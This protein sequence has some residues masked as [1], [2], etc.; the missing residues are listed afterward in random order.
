MPT[1]KLQNYGKGWGGPQLR[2]PPLAGQGRA[3]KIAFLGG[4][5][6]T[7]KLAPWF[8]PTWELWAHASCRD[9]CARMPDVLFDLHPPELWRDPTKKTWDTSY[10]EFLKQNTVPIYMQQHY[11]DVPASI[12]Y[13]FDQ[14]VSQFRPYFT[15]HVAW[16]A[17]L[18]L[19][20]GVTHVGL[21]GCHYESDS[22]YGIQ[23][24]CAEYWCGVLDGRGVHLII[25][26][27][28]DLLDDPHE[29]YGY[30]SHEGGRRIASYNK[31]V[32]KP[33][34]V[35]TPK[36]EKPI[37]LLTDETPASERPP[38]RTLTDPNGNPV[39]TDFTHSGLL[40]HA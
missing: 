35:Q 29:L 2:R 10:H 30:E 5:K 1:I 32:V 40:I 19:M 3:R 16:M 26:R 11:P 8:D 25:P 14:A 28:C 34:T 22:E 7:L 18:A 15:N 33:E 27:G 17:A 37:T 36:E 38:L 20:E 12:A 6:S 31:R 13:P 21:Y 39:K 24:G 23:R 4:A 9:Q